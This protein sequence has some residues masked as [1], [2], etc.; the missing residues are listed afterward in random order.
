M[1][2]A[3][4][5]IAPFAA[6]SS[7]ARPIA[8]T[9]HQRTES[10][11]SLR[12]QTSDGSSGSSLPTPGFPPTLQP[13]W[14]YQPSRPPSSGMSAAIA[15]TA[16]LDLD[17]NVIRANRPFQQILSNDQDVRGKQLQ[18]LVVAADGESFIALRARLK[19]ERESRE[20]AYMPPMLQSGEDPIR[21][22]SEDDIE[23]LAGGFSDQTYTWSRAVPGPQRETFPARVRLAKATAY[24]VVVTLPSFRPVDVLP[25]QSSATLPPPGFMIPPPRAPTLPGQSME[26]RTDTQ[27]AP[28][29]SYYPSA[30]PMAGVQQF[31]MIAGQP[32]QGR[33]YASIQPYPTGPFLVGTPQRPPPVTPRLPTAE[34]PM[35]VTPITPLTTAPM[36]PSQRAPA[37][38]LPPIAATPPSQVLIPTAGSSGAAEVQQGPSD[39]DEESPKKRRRMDISD[40]LQQ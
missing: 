9:R 10:L 25:P 23:R 1:A 24:F 11:R 30:S 2:P 40:V 36:L 4:S 28:P 29:R 31:A 39:D 5:H 17:F 19:G 14:I 12:S 15:P 37:M 26:S 33:P 13:G 16:F 3:P 34:P 38:L 22:V 20:P 32:L 7:T 21:G 6:G 8:R 18:D 35:H 27:T